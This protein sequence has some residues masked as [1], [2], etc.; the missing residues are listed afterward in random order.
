M[1]LLGLLLLC[2]AAAFT[3]L[4]IANNISGGQDQTVVLFGSTTV[5]MNGLEIFLAGAALA[6]VFGLGLVT[7]GAGASLL[8]RRRTRLRTAHRALSRLTRRPAGAPGAPGASLRSRL[9][10]RFGH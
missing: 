10:Q 7:A 8:R 9:L 5:T 3:G 4:L 1:L 6:L 2:G